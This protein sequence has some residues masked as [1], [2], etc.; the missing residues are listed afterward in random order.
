MVTEEQIARINELYKKQKS[1]G[2]TEEEKN[3]QQKLRKLYIDSMKESLKAQLKNVKIVTL[4]EYEKLKKEKGNSCSC[5][6]GHDHD[7]S[8]HHG[9][10][11]S[12]KE[13]KN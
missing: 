7:H 13:H 6:C 11:C 8:H 4:E 1:E 12:C 3:E 2:L 10:G 5:G 9:E